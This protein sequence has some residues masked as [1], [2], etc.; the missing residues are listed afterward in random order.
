[1]KKTTITLLIA[2]FIALCFAHGAVGAEDALPADAK[3]L[4]AK[5]DEDVVKAQRALVAGLT[6]AQEKA[7]KSGN[8]EA[9]NAIKAKIDETVKILGEDGSLLGGDAAVDGPKHS[10]KVVMLYALPDFK[11]PAIIFKTIDVITDATAAGLANDGLRSVKVPEGFTVTIFEGEN[12]GGNSR[13]LNGDTAV[14]G[15]VGASG[16]SSFIIQRVK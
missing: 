1:M 13:V 12:G 14:V 5:C 15:N 16:V 3:K 6:K 9:A 10:S 7:T 2:L 8:L 11:G 4:I